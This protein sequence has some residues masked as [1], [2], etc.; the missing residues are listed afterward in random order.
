MLNQQITATKQ[1][2]EA[3]IF[4]MFSLYTADQVWTLIGIITSL[5]YAL[6]LLRLLETTYMPQQEPPR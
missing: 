4:K 1:E 3:L 5:E 6:N 2:V